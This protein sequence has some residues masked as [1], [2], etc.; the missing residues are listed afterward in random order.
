MSRGSGRRGLVPGLLPVLAFMLAAAGIWAYVAEDRDDDVKQATAADEAAGRYVS[1][2]ATFRAHVLH[3]LARH[4]G[5]HPA[6]LRDILDEE[7]PKFPTLPSPAPPGAE[8][9]KSYQ[10]AVETSRTALKPVA[11]L[12]AQLD[13]AAQAEA[14]VATANQALER[15]MNALL[16]TGLVFDVEPVKSRTLPELRAALAD[17][18]RVPAPAKGKPAEQAVVGAISHAIAEVETLIDK[19][20]AGG[21]YSY[22]LSDEFTAAETQVKDYAIDVDGDVREAVARLR[23]AA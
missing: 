9:S 6:E 1:D 19:M 16:S 21:S 14:F 5:A 15:S 7:I 23:D 13:T 11:D 4:R 12:R 8:D 20:E 18:R 3:R 17:V 22:D 10:A 2:V